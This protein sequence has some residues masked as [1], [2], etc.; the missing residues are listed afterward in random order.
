VKILFRNINS[1]RKLGKIPT[2][3][4]PLLPL[5]FPDFLRFPL[6]AVRSNLDS[7]LIKKQLKSKKPGKRNRF[8]KSFNWAQI[9]QNPEME[10][11]VRS[12][13]EKDFLGRKYTSNMMLR[14]NRRK[15]LQEWPFANLEILSAAGLNIELRII[16][17]LKNVK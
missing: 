3:Q 9:Y 14:A 1:L 4:I 15:D 8:F 12:Y 11:N 5:V 17:E 2:S 7:L 16:N 13:F 6:W 10:E